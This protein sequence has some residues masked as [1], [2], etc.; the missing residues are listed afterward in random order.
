MD[1]IRDIKGPVPVPEPAGPGGLLAGLGLA[2]LCGLAVWRW[3]RRRLRP[4]RPALRAAV[5]A[6]DALE[7]EGGALAD[8]DHYFRLAEVVRRILAVRLGEAATAMT[9]AEL[10]PLLTRLA[11]DMAAE[12]AA[13]LARAEAVCY[14]G[15]AVDAQARRSDGQTA[16]RLATAPL[17]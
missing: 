11:P 9:T 14:A 5:R 8:R 17:P 15:L 4:G 3:R 2:A 10:E 6:L 16:R 1:D 13:L 12:A 7:G